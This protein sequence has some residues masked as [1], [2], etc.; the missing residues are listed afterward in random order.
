MKGRTDQKWLGT[1]NDMCI[2]DEVIK[3]VYKYMSEEVINWGIHNVC[4]EVSRD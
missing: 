1:N 4:N 2:R 3:Y